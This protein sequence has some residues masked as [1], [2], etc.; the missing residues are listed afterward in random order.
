MFRYPKCENAF[1]L[2]ITCFVSGRAALKLR[3]LKNGNRKFREAIM[4]VF[5][6]VLFGAG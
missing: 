5:N 2:K 3:V 4:D 1:Y 6:F